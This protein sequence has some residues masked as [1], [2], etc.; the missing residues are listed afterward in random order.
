MALALAKSDRLRPK[1][2]LALPSSVAEPVNLGER[3]M[4]VWAAVSSDRYSHHA[5]SFAGV[6]ATGVITVRLAEVSIRVGF[7]TGASAALMTRISLA[8]SNMERRKPSPSRLDC[9]AQPAKLNM[10]NHSAKPRFLEEEWFA[11]AMNDLA[12]CG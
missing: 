5:G 9:P 7:N 8:G 2:T 12:H 11:I 3:M 4:A 6:D 10:V 1:D